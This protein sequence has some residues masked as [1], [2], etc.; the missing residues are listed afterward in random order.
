MVVPR[1]SGLIFI[2]LLWQGFILFEQA[3]ARADA[4]FKREVQRLKGEQAYLL[5][6]SVEK[7]EMA[8]AK[9]EGEGEGEGE[10]EEDYEDEGVMVF[11]TTWMEILLGGV[12]AGLWTGEL[13][14]SSS[15]SSIKVSSLTS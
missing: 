9:G 10:R 11:T 13:L 7:E 5:P 2:T 6:K 15:A 12:V 14:V 8:G 1:L 3:D 4:V